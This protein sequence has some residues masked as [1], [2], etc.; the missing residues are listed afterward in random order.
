[1]FTTLYPEPLKSNL[2]CQ[3][4]NFS[5]IYFNIILTPVHTSPKKRLWV[6]RYKHFPFSKY[7]LQIS[8]ISYVY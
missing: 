5:K 3:T 1:M 8:S 7:E 6:K 2:N 4:P